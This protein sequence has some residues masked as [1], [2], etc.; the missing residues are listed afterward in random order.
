MVAISFLHPL[1]IASRHKKFLRCKRAEKGTDIVKA[2]FSHLECTSGNIQKSHSALV[3]EECQSGNVIMLFLLQKLL[4]ECHT[5]CDEFGDP[6]LDDILCQLRILQLVAHRHLVARTDKPRKICLE[7]MMWESGHR[8]RS[9]SSARTLCEHYSQHFAGYKRIIAVCF[10]KI[11]APEQ[12]NCF[13]MLRLHR[14][15]L[16]H[17]RCLGRFLFCHNRVFIILQNYRFF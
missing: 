10:V 12:K 17:H 1:F 5:W 3:L 7:G 4:I 11:A 15:E 8:N 6:S 13:R 2:S 16:L 14:E 9:R